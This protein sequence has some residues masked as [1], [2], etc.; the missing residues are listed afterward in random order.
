MP[1]RELATGRPTGSAMPLAWAHA[2]YLKLRRSIADRTI[3][4]LPRQAVTRYGNRTAESVRAPWRFE[5]TCSAIEPGQVLRI[6]LRAAARVHWGIDGFE[7][8]GDVETRDTGLGMHV[9][10]LATEKLPPGT[11][12]D[13][14]FHWRDANRWEGKDF[15]VVMAS[16][17]MRRRDGLGTKGASSGSRASDPR[18]EARHEAWRLVMKVHPGNTH[19][20][21]D[22]DAFVRDPGGG[23]ASFRDAFA[24]ELAEEF[25]W[26]VTGSDDLPSEHKARSIGR[27]WRRGGTRRRR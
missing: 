10:D 22:G 13:F 20:R 19:R 11:A 24:E 23:P 16:P 18:M 1:E 17:A 14:T 15:R 2:E 4:D 3:F 25:V 8:S 9:A 12:V 21:D 5:H 27:S 7:Q 26:S 6:E